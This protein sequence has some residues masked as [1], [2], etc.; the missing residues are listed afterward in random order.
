MADEA[1]YRP[2]AQTDRARPRG[3]V[4][5]AGGSSW[6]SHAE[7]LVRGREGEVVPVSEIP[8][9]V[10]DNLTVQHAPICGLDLGTPRLFGVLNT[11]PDSFSDGGRFR[12]FDA[13]IAHARALV[14]GGADILDIGGESTRPGADFVPVEEEI[15]RT[16]PVI[17][18]LR[19]EGIR[20][21]ISID[22][23]KAQV[24][25]AALAA[26][27]NLINDVTALSFDPDM[28]SVVRDSGKPVCLMHASGDPK[29]MQDNP[30]YDDVLLDV[31]DYLKAR[32][33]HAVGLGIPKGTLI[34]DPGIGFGKTMQHNLALIR[35]LSLFCGLGCAILLGVSRKRFIGTIGN[36]PQ[37]DRRAPGSIA[38]G[39]EGVRQGV[40]FLRVH[41]IPETN[42]A[43][44]LWQ[45][46]R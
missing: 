16:E 21:P 23:R 39:L 29:T 38:L 35:G 4:A 15:A 41:D 12:G 10:L 28:A 44:R 11:T 14:D 24:A 18:A 30:Q 32:V 3:A 9:E 2:I 40:Q 25:E 37:A 1:Y 42:Q 7:R 31:Y 26:G 27:A 33:D 20:V 22:T 45:A 36:E 13:A 19:A 6:F 5:L 34:V 8:D 46:A 17:R 43:L